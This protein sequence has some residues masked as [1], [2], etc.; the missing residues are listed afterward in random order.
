MGKPAGRACARPGVLSADARPTGTRAHQ[1]FPLWTLPD[2]RRALP[3][4][5]P[6]RKGPG[7]YAR[8]LFDCSAISEPAQLSLTSG[9]AHNVRVGAPPR[10]I[11]RSGG[12]CRQ[13]P[14]PPRLH[15]G[16][17]LCT[18]CQTNVAQCTRRLGGLVGNA[19]CARIWPFRG[20]LG[21]VIEAGPA[22]VGRYRALKSKPG[23]RLPAS[24][25]A[26][27][28]GVRRGVDQTI[29]SART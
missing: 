16:P 24:Y 12:V 9:L 2:H 13:P 19:A 28:R 26:P 14:T 18:N 3:R 29:F 22:L 10:D 1:R 8:P 21:T 11:S 20:L 6:S 25:R 7:S 27:V 5:K 17:G 4:R 15:P 23:R